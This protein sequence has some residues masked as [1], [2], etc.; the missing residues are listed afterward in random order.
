MA[1][2]GKFL[3]ENI[4]VHADSRSD[5]RRKTAIT[6]G[7]RR[8]FQTCPANYNE[9]KLQGLVEYYTAKKAVKKVQIIQALIYFKAVACYKN[10]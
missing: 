1:D 8:S 3:E 6:S 5:L 7:I 2:I 10:V 9:E 4:S